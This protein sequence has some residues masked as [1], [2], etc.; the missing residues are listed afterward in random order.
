ME[1]EMLVTCPECGKNI[2]EKADPC[3]YCGF[4]DAGRKSQEYAEQYVSKYRKGSVECINCHI[5]MS[6]KEYEIL[7]C[8]KFAMGYIGT[9]R[10]RCPKCGEENLKVSDYS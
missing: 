8:R 10:F 1:G 6:V 4:P 9:V 7:D 3:L 5:E 2:S